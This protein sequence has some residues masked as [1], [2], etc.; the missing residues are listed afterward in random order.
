MFEYPVIYVVDDFYCIIYIFGLLINVIDN[1][2]VVQHFQHSHKYA[3]FDIF[4][5][6]VFFSNDD[7]IVDVSV[8]CVRVVCE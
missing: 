3:D 6:V 5:H 4:D 1:V 7:V 8:N 2:I